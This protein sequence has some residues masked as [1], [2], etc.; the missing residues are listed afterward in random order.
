MQKIER[1]TIPD[2]NKRIAS[3]IY[4]NGSAIAYQ[5]TDQLQ[6]YNNTVLL[7]YLLCH[8]WGRGLHFRTCNRKSGTAY[9]FY[10]QTPYKIG[11]SET[12]HPNKTQNTTSVMSST[13]PPFYAIFTTSHYT[14]NH[15]S[16]TKNTIN[17]LKN[18]ASLELNR[19]HHI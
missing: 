14:K 17:T 5:T 2:K 4:C 9:L 7:Y 15:H 16:N 6:T 11:I 3:W 10:P 13:K 1:F 18:K 19:K 8:M 12:F